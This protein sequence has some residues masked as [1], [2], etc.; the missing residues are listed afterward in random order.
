MACTRCAV[1]MIFLCR[2]DVL[3]RSLVVFS[4]ETLQLYHSLSK[5]PNI[6]TEKILNNGELE[7]MLNE[8]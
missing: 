7:L 1:Y 8:G 4:A 2:F 3:L 5:H 6:L